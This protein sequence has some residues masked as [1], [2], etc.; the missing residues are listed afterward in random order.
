MILER[1]RKGEEGRE[2]NIDVREKDQLVASCM[3]PDQGLSQDQ[4]PNPQPRHVPWPGI[5]PAA[6][7]LWDNTP[8]NSAKPARATHIILKVF[9]KRRKRRA[10]ALV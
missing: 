7:R 10:P 5:K 4:G 1:E 8:I 2:R 6:F 9:S 3:L